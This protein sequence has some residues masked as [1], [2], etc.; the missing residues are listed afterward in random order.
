[1][2][3][4]K[5]LYR[6]NEFCL[7][8]THC[9][10]RKLQFAFVAGV[11]LAAVVLFVCALYLSIESDV[12]VTLS[13]RKK[14]LY[15]GMYFDYEWKSGHWPMGDLS[16]P[17]FVECIVTDDESENGTSDALI[18]H[19]AYK[20]A[21][22]DLP[23]QAHRNP[24]QVWVFLTLESPPYAGEFFGGKSIINLTMTY[25]NSSDVQLLTYGAIEPGTYLGGFNQSRNY[26]HGKNR[27]VVVVISNCVEQP[28]LNYVKALSKFIDVDIFGQCGDREL[29]HNCWDQLQPYKFYLAFENNVCID[30][31]TEKF[32]K[33]G[34]S[35]GMVPVVLGGA[36]Y[37]NPSVA[38]PGSY[39]DARNFTSVES[40]ADFLREVGSDS[41]RYNQYFRWLSSYRVRWR[42]HEVELCQLCT[43][44]HQ[45]RIPKT[46]TDVL[47]WYNLAGHC[48]RY[49]HVDMP[50]SDLTTQHSRNTTTIPDEGSKQTETS[51]EKEDASKILGQN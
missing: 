40:L 11:V 29:C 8:A 27:S 13:R 7:R 28:R 49:P 32:Y 22:L 39:I 12:L 48:E 47:A 38:P 10:I 23:S 18:F 6:S 31:V 44:L 50:E 5:A 34:L 45:N 46:Y 51:K 25:L 17:N 33:N 2:A 4:V 20:T 16:C 9:T 42:G 3:R 41:R 35:H 30:Y 26:L 19:G 14:I 37:S 15:W 36:N 24:S 43:L 1:M 21:L